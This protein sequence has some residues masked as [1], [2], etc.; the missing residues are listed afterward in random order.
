MLNKKIYSQKISISHTPN[1]YNSDFKPS[2]ARFTDSSS[3]H[4]IVNL[5]GYDFL[6]MDWDEKEKDLIVYETLKYDYGKITHM[7]SHRDNRFYLVYTEKHHKLIELYRQSS[8]D[9][10]D[11]ITESYF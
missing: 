8:E 10:E 3:M 6:A 1:V 2:A 4:R 11:S 7:S 5:F 9:L